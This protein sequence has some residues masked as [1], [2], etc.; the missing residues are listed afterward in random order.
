MQVLGETRL[1]FG[2]EDGAPRDAEEVDRV[3]AQRA[4]NRV[5]VAG[6]VRGGQ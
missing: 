2:A 1:Q 4:P 3:Q 6:S 5:D